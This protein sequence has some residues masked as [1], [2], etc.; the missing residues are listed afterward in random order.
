MRSF[1]A[2]LGGLVAALVAAPLA[3]DDAE[4]ELARRFAETIQP[5]VKTHC[6]GCHGEAKQEGKLS[7]SRFTSATTVGKDHRVWELVRERLMAR[8][9]PP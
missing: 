8:E 3:A 9:M 1:S 4:A 7:L 6:Q 2:I 5:L